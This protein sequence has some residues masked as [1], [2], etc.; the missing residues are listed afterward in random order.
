VMLI[1]EWRAPRWSLPRLLYVAGLASMVALA[2]HA[3]SPFL[4][5][6]V[7]TSQHWIVATGLASETPASA[8]RGAVVL[9][10]VLGS[11]AL[12]PFFEVEASFDGSATYG[13]W[14]FGAFASA[15]RTSSWVPA[16]LALGFASGFVHYLLDRSVYRFSDPA[17]RSAAAGLF[18]H[19][20][21]HATPTVARGRPMRT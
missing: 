14:I 17:V 12:L 13:D 15:L 5:L 9:G 16:L 6:V 8:R 10:L 11:I 18:R 19:D 21:W 4:F 1:A 20:G 3:R 7:W 2:L